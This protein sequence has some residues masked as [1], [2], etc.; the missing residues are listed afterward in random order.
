MYIILSPIFFALLSSFSQL[1]AKNTKFAKFISA[2]LLGI[3]GLSAIFFGILT[4]LHKGNVTFEIPVGINNIFWHFRLDALSGFFYIIIGIITT[5]VAIYAPAY[6][7]SYKKNNSIKFINFFTGLFIAGMSLVL[8]ANDVYTF[9]FSWE[10]MSLSS[11]FLVIEQHQYTANRKAA[12]IYL[13]MAHASGLLI[14]SAFAFLMKTSGD[15][16]FASFHNIDM[17]FMWANIAFF[18]AF[19]GFGMK[20][21][22]VPLHVWLPQAHPVAPSHIS[23]LMSGVMLKIAIYGFIR[24]CFSF[25]T[26]IHWQWGVVVVSFGTISA[27]MGILYAIVQNDLKRLLAYS[28]VENIGIIFIGI[29]FA[30]IFFAT[31]YPL[32]ATLGLIAA[33]YHCLN[34]AIFK[35]LLFLN[36]GAIIQ[37]S[38]EHDLEQMGGL[39]HRMPQTAFLFLIGCIS[40]S[41]LPPFNGFV[42]EWLTFQSALQAPI[43][44]SGILRILIPVTAAILALTGA[45]TAACFV[46]VFGIAFLGKPRVSNIKSP[47]ETSISIRFSMLVLGIICLLLGVFPTF[48]INAINNICSE[49][50]G[51]TLLNNSTNN[52][53]WLFP[54]TNNIA[55]Y[56]APLII[57]GILSGLFLAYLLMKL[58]PHKLKDKTALP[59]DCGFGGLNSRMQ[60]SATAF[61]MPIRRI[62]SSIWKVEETIEKNNSTKSN[63]IKFDGIKYNLIVSD[64]IWLFFYEPL[65]KLIY[66]ITRIAA[67]MQGGNIRIYL[68]YI[69]ATLLILLWTIA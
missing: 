21:G 44:Q 5:V 63:A 6:L 23:A 15:Y 56:S 62:F 58:I 33:L 45:I 29:G 54:K 26:S 18:C 43:L 20:A 24:F 19:L 32:L 53:L 69:L 60:Y 59:W 27:I 37:Q 12:F 48:I 57:V 14:L 17:P 40:I 61:A 11:Y 47:R 31:N 68:I 1:L 39:V 22:I 9:M 13:I 7:R 3:S 67:R 51:I 34:H 64:R 55:S 50:L 38:H 25:F 46:K 66:K 2:V 16:T 41:A 36:A 52:W 35:S 10:I 65:T 4:L 28:S 42:S 30:M 8:V 49:I